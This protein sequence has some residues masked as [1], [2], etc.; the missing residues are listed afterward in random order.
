MQREE[1]KRLKKEAA[2]KAQE[3]KLRERLEKGKLPPQDLFKTPE[4][5][6]WDAEVL[7]SGV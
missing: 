4:F 5:S 3:Q 7:S 1:E 2:A 6:Q